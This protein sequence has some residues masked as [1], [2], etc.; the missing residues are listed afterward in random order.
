MKM[1]NGERLVGIKA[2]EV[3]GELTFYDTSVLPPVVR[4]VQVSDVVSTTR[5]NGSIMPSDYASRLPLQQLL[6]LVAFLKSSADR[7][8]TVVG[9]DDVVREPSQTR[10]ER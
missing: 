6:D 7:T 2:E 9:F 5:L 4:T 1:R 8:P 10:R 3:G